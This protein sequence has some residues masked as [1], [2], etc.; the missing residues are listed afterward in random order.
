[1]K[2]IICVYMYVLPIVLHWVLANEIFLRSIDDIHKQNYR[3]TG[4]GELEQAFSKHFN[5]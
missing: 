4:I 5:K 1:M 3:T 2:S